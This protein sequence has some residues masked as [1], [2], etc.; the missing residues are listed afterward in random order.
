MENK[1]E[2]IKQNS[3]IDNFVKTD[4]ILKDMCEIIEFSQ[5]TAYQAVNTTLIHRNWL[6]S[7]R[8]ASEELQDEDRAKY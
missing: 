2:K 3:L 7:Y 5:K 6:L 1:S 4:N 8:I